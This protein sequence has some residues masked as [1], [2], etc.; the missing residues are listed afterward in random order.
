MEQMDN[1][2]TDFSPTFIKTPG[3]A[4]SLLPLHP[5]LGLHLQKI[6]LAVQ[7]L[8][9][10]HG[11]VVELSSKL[12]QERLDLEQ[13]VEDIQMTHKNKMEQLSGRR[14]QFVSC[15][16]EQLS[17]VG[18]AVIQ[19]VKMLRQQFR[20]ARQEVDTLADKLKEMEDKGMRKKEFN[21]RENDDHEIQE[22]LGKLLRYNLE[23]LKEEQTVLSSVLQA[24]RETNNYLHQD[25]V[26]MD[27]MVK[28]LEEENKGLEKKVWEKDAIVVPGMVGLVK[29][30]AGEEKLV[31][32]ENVEDV[33]AKE[34]LLEVVL[35]EKLCELES[36]QNCVEGSQKIVAQMRSCS[37]G[38]VVDEV[39]MAF[40]LEIEL[41][42]VSR[43]WVGEQRDYEIELQNSRKKIAC[44][45]DQKKEREKMENYFLETLSEKDEEFCEK[46]IEDIGSYDSPL[47]NDAGKLSDD[48]DG[49]MEEEFNI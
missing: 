16:V 24:G 19:D 30:E 15:Q 49:Q 23:K 32:E 41:E 37:M 27:R 47:Y 38:A 34:N 22:K 20:E 28:L 33:E 40:K 29:A 39:D 42:D 14:D 17:C 36:I 46:V 3:C 26:M 4:M 43:L 2:T 31:L 9:V 12:V 35:G 18:A 13:E 21:D 25:R 11:R 48:K 44:L 5:Q 7:R 45:E 6:V 8:R 10:E 1:I